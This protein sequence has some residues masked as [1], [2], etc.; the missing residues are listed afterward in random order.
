MG[1]T[2]P[3]PGA[4]ILNRT[5]GM[6]V[7]S[8]KLTG[9]L[10]GV[11]KSWLGKA[12]TET[13]AAQPGPARANAPSS[14][15]GQAEPGPATAAQLPP[16]SLALPVDTILRQLP[17]ELQSRVV[18]PHSDISLP[19]PLQ[20]ILPQLAHGSVKISFGELR[21]L[22][23]GIFSTATDRDH[24]LVQLPLAEI[25]ARLDPALLRRRQ[26]QR[27]IEV[28]DDIVGPFA[29][30]G[31]GVFISTPEPVTQPRAQNARPT[32][33]PQPQPVVEPKPIPKPV[34]PPPPTP[35]PAPGL[36]GA[37]PTPARVQTP[38][39]QA[40]ATPRAPAPKQ[41]PPQAAPQPAP[42]S[43]ERKPTKPAVGQPVSA[44]A[45]P[46]PAPKPAAEQQAAA[47]PPASDQDVLLVPLNQLS[48][49]W[50]ELVK[51][52]I[53]VSNLTRA[54]VALP[55]NFVEA[56][57]KHARVT[58]TW[59]QIRGWLRPPQPK[60]A[61]SMC[62]DITLELPL[63]VI[64]PLFL[65]RSPRTTQQK[66]AE[67]D[68]TIPDVFYPPGVTPHPDL[69]PPGRTSPAPETVA[70]GGIAAQ[71]TEPGKPQ[72][73]P[74]TDYYVWQDEKDTALEPAKVFKR[75]TNTPSTDFLKRYAPPAEIVARAAALEGVVGALIA[76]PDGLLVA[77]DVP[78]EYN[79]DTL[80]GFLPQ[81]FAKVSQCTKELRMGE[82]NNLNFT[83]GNVPWRIFKVGGI[84]FAAFGRA[85]V[86]LPTA[87]LA[88]LAA[89][90]DRKPRQ[91]V[92]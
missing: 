25:L 4:Q 27:R 6:S 42:A 59:K 1:I 62:D 88:A 70:P 26:D 9:K 3:Q 28:P 73:L 61:A 66:K 19:I 24:V 30:Y 85:G 32:A 43:N 22:A 90:L 69:A 68:A 72:K 39:P 5:Y 83:V 52:E 54:L 60:D 56:G 78:P 92:Q 16:N 76:L 17:P 13:S 75:G 65:S 53:A 50:P 91:A 89:E 36:V 38:K 51:Q 46:R 31:K 20:T 84:F 41:A 63:R 14:V 35:P 37:Q 8:Q 77:A 2:L 58:C 15:S 7:I 71:T 81:M 29:D 11:L 12:S 45:Q 21:T 47:K 82:L 87:Q 23:P 49:G 44:V 48:E 40:P 74:E 18:A 80:A 67:F 57:L 10:G 34:Q 79:A 33:P 55:L 64:A 86:P